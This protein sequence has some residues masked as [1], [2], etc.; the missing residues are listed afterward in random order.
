MNHASE[1]T[2]SSLEYEHNDLERL[3]ESHQRALIARDI[4]AALATITAFENQLKWHIGYEEE[5]LLPLYKA[6]AGEVEG[7]TLPIFQAEHRKL[8]QS[9]ASLAQHTGSLYTVSDMVGS[10]LNLLDEEALFKGL[11]NHHALREQNL[12]F[13]RLDAVTSET[14]R[15]EALKE[16]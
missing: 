11:F 1:H 16:H 13:P 9:A 2:F 15:E 8:R 10:I 12:L 4:D 3:F 5:V 7:G 14:E 6:K